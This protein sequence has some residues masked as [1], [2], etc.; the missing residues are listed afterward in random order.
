MD[1]AGVK[2][3]PADSEPTEYGAPEPPRPGA[4][5]EERL[6]LL[7]QTGLSPEEAALLVPAEVAAEES[8]QPLPPEAS[9]GETTRRRRQ[10]PGR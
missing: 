7:H 9:R 2:R 3:E 1:P 4:G 10:P 5:G 6:R 8:E